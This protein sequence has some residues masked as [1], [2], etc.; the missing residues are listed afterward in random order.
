MSYIESSEWDETETE[1]DEYEEDAGEAVLRN[2]R[3]LFI[4][5]WM[6]KGTSHQRLE[7]NNII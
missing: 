2:E 1:L 6:N 3:E 7:L 4:S 5:E